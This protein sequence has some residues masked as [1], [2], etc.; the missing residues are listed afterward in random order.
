[1]ISDAEI[2]KLLGDDSDNG[3]SLP[4]LVE[5]CQKE[6]GSVLPFVG[7]GLSK[8][9][10]F[11]L[12]DE[13]LKASAANRPKLQEKIQSR[14]TDKQYEEAASDLTAVLMPSIFQSKLANAF[15]DSVIK[16]DRPITGAVA[17]LVRFPDARLITTNF[18]RVLETCFRQ[19]N[20]ELRA[21]PGSQAKYG[22]E[23][24]QQSKPFLLKLHGDWE[25]FENRVLTLEEYEKAYGHSSPECMDVSLPLPHLLTLLLETRCMLFLGCSLAQDRT[26]QVLSNVTKQFP[27]RIYHFAIVERPDGATPDEADTAAHQR[28]IELDSLS[29]IPIWYPHGKHDLIEAILTYLA[30]KI[31]EVFPPRR[32]IP[33]NLPVLGNATVGRQADIINLLIDSPEIRRLID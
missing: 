31:E 22:V 15:G 18:D 16:R 10:G 2:Q 27:N 8:S 13:F 19:H 24:L 9:W 12:W 14:I 33:H 6:K 32:V 7:A 17:Q 20:I 23:A 25:D 3:D 30:E 29:I 1:M 21:F 28:K 11:P 4:F 26:M 5:R